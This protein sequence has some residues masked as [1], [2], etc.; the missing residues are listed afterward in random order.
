MPWIGNVMR[1]P[2]VRRQQ[3]Q[4]FTVSIQSARWINIGNIDVLT[5]CRAP[6]GI[7]KTG[8]YVVGFVKNQ[9]AWGTAHRH[10]RATLSKKLVAIAT[11]E[12]E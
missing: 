1:Q 10:R 4:P 5:Q 2:T 6:L 7:G 11:Q 3:Q 8:Q 9:G 12:R